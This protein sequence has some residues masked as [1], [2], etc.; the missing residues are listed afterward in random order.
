MKS[1]K[2]LGF[3]SDHSILTAAV[4]N[5]KLLFTKF[6]IELNYLL[7]ASDHVGIKTYNIVDHSGLLNAYILTYT[8]DSYEL[9][10]GCYIFM[11]K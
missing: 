4:I 7:S 3:T 1:V 2:S 8:Y 10:C 9:L 5:V 6:F 11:D